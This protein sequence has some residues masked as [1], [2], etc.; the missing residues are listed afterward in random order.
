MYIDRHTF[1][2]TPGAE[3]D[4]EESCLAIDFPAL[5]IT[6]DLTCHTNWHTPPFILGIECVTL[7]LFT[8][9]FT[10]QDWIWQ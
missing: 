7:P 8:L 9:Y 10:S 4:V 2:F 1:L 6:G 5:Y 3:L